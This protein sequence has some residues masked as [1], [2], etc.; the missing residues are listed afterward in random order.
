MPKVESFNCPNCGATLKDKKAKVCEYC[1]S[2]IEVEPEFPKEGEYS[3]HA[4]EVVYFRNLP[5]QAI[6]IDTTDIPFQP[7]ITYE[8]LPGGLLDSRL[9]KDADEIVSL[10]KATQEACNTED[11]DLYV[12]TISPLNRAFYNQARKGAVEQFITGDMKRYTVSIDFLELTLDTAK[13]N[14]TIEAIIFQTSGR[15]TQPKATFQYQLIKHQGHWKVANSTTKIA[16]GALKNVFKVS[17]LSCIIPLIGF[18]I[19]MVAGVWAIVASLNSSCSDATEQVS[20]STQF[21]VYRSTQPS[22]EGEVSKVDET[23]LGEGEV[24]IEGALPI[25]T[26]PDEGDMPAYVI[27]PGAKIAVVSKSGEWSFIRTEDGRTGWTL[28]VLLE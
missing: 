11:L 19:G 25:Y 7:K 8:K 20:H 21:E 5:G 13:A 27:M 22:V 4:G 15:T 10:V 9:K 2:A 26:Q 1:G 28:S 14:I 17:K 16:V 6:T 23:E 24:I 18:L 3:P 12:S